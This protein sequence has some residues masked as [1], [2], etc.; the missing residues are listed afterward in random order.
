MK[1][2]MKT[3]EEIKKILEEYK[4]TLR[5]KYGVKEIGIFGSYVRK[6]TKRASDVDILVEFDR[7][8]DLLEFISLEDHLKGILK[9]KVDLVMKDALKPRIGKCILREVVYI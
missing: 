1:E 4:E 5:E 9:V 6:E 2:G 8:I 7:T 3:L